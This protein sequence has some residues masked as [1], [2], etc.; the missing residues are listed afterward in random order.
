M[1]EWLK[2]VFS[3]G[4]FFTLALTLLLLYFL[5]NFAQRMLPKIGITER[6]GLP[7][8]KGIDY[9]LLLYEPL[10]LLVLSSAFIL[11]NPLFH[12]LLLSLL[13]LAG[14][15][16]F[17][18]Y[19]SGRIVQFDRS[20]SVGQQLR[21]KEVQGMI[22]EKGRLGLRLRSN[23]GLHFVA[24]SKLIGDGYL[25]LSGEEIG[26]FYLLG[27]S[28]REEEKEK[29]DHAKRLAD[30]LATTPYLDWLHTPELRRSND[31][32]YP[33]QIRVSVRE[34]NHLRDLMVLIEQEWN[35]ACKISKNKN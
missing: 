17:K 13:L 16:H 15:N 27:L 18:N 7:L 21:I 26:G 35:Y 28:P 11:L 14:F 20:I 8:Q 19:I 2:S 3:W 34:E 1:P 10:V 5:L 31:S 6:V 12:G 9:L 25:L 24:Y 30:L 32:N 33:Y 23:K 22:A 4:D 29:V